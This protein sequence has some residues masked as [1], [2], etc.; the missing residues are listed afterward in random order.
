MSQTDRREKRMYQETKIEKPLSSQ[1]RLMKVK[2]RNKINGTNGNSHLILETKKEHSKDMART[3]K[4]QK[5]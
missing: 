2:I 5:Q 4:W 3:K 1:N